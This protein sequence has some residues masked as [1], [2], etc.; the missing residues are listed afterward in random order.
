MC[1]FMACFVGI[2]GGIDAFSILATIRST[3]A[4]SSFR[5]ADQL[6]RYSALVFIRSYLELACLIFIWKSRDS[7]LRR[8]TDYGQSIP[9]TGNI[10][11]EPIP[12]FLGVASLCN[13]SLHLSSLRCAI[14]TRHSGQST[15]SI[16]RQY[17]K[18]KFSSPCMERMPH[19]VL[20]WG[21]SPFM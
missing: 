11:A 19:P 16:S 5:I 8:F 10:V 9:R 17:T 7:I 6:L 18:S 15:L 4:R 12:N 2:A 20:V 21:I 3:L 1:S 14:L 13:S